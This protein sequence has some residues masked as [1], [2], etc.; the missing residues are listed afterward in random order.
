MARHGRRPALALRLRGLRTPDVDGPSCLE[1]PHLPECHPRRTHSQVGDTWVTV[2]Q[3]ACQQKKSGTER[4]SS[5]IAP[6]TPSATPGEYRS[7]GVACS[8]Q[9]GYNERGRMSSRARQGRRSG[10]AAT[11][12]IR[13]ALESDYD[14]IHQ[15]FELAE[16][17][18]HR[19]LPHVYKDPTRPVRT[20]E[21]LQKAISTDGSTLLVAEAAGQLVGMVRAAAFSGPSL[22]P[23]GVGQ[24]GYL[25]VIEPLRRLGIGTSLL[26][27]AHR[28]ILEREVTR[29]DAEALRADDAAY[30]FFVGHG[31][32]EITQVRSHVVGDSPPRVSPSIR[33][34]VASDYAAVSD[35]LFDTLLYHSEIAP[36]EYGPPEPPGISRD[37]YD[38]ILDDENQ[39]CVV[40][41]VDG[42][43]GVARTRKTASAAYVGGLV[44]MTS[45]VHVPEEHRGKGV[46]RALMEAI[47]R[48]AADHD[49]PR[50]QLRVS[51]ANKDA[52]AFYDRIDYELMSAMMTTRLEA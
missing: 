27:R 11:F 34:A 49:V 23:T 6:F 26:N 51:Q 48:W 46:G 44:A 12:A 29:V 5:R 1:L 20:L 39:S 36:D 30:N 45:H 18:N 43:V 32:H 47:E 4:C 40:A 9:Y 15:L 19:L 42:V 16:R 50:V 37:A 2:A 33:D 17:R 7:V 3:H 25:Y 10:R 21:Y 24:V 35:L 14:A 52:I 28:W 31:Y 13:T 8:V 38:A 41:D 22:P